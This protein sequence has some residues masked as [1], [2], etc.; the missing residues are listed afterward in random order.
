[1]NSI[2]G[3]QD[4]RVSLTKHGLLFNDVRLV[5]KDPR[6]LNNEINTCLLGANHN[7]FIL[8]H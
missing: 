2:E 3:Q 5:A 7:H 6:K 1:M 4:L 8:N